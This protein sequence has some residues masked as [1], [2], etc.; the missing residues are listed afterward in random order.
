MY[1]W[2]SKPNSLDGLEEPI[3]TDNIITNN[4]VTSKQSDKNFFP[5]KFHLYLRNSTNIGC[6][7]HRSLL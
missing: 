3:K 2:C 5:Y 4:K 6:V 1:S 7:K